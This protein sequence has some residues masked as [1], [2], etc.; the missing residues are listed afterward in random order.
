MPVRK[1]NIT[2]FFIPLFVLFFCLT[3]WYA[4]QSM[5]F[6][7]VPA[8]NAV[9]DLSGLSF[10]ARN[11]KITGPVAYIPNALLTPEEF[12]T[13]E[14]EAVVGAPDD[15]VQYYSS[16]IRVLLP[17][18]GYYTFS[19]RSVDF[20]HRMYV[21]GRLVFEMGRP[22]TSK[23]TSVPDTGRVTL[24]LKAENGELDI[25]QQSSN[26]VHREGGGHSGWNIGPVGNMRDKLAS[27]FRENIVLGCFF[28]LFFVHTILFLLLRSYRANLYFALFCLTWFLRSGIIGPKVFTVLF[29]WI[30]WAV[31]FRI[32]YLSIPVTAAL[33]IALLNTLFPGVLQK[34]FRYALY[35]ISGVSS[36]LFLFSDTV[37]MS[38]ALPVCEA[39]Y[40]PAVLYIVVRFI[41]KQRNISAE[42]G[43]FLAGVALFVFAAVHDMLYYNGIYIIYVADLTAVS[44]LM[45]SFCEAAAIF[46]ATVREVEYAK[47][48]EQR[49]ALENAALGRVNRLRTNMMATISHEMRTPLTVMSVY[50]QL[51]VETLRGQNVDEQ[52]AADLAMISEEAKRLADMASGVMT[53]TKEQENSETRGPIDLVAV[54]RQTARLCSP[55]LAKNKN[56]LTLDLPE[57]LPQI[58]GNAGE[59]AQVLWNLLGN[60]ARHTQNGTVSIRAALDEDN[61]AVTVSDTGEGITAEL[62]PHIFERSVSGDGER[63]GLGLAICK[64]IVDAHGGEIAIQSAK[65]QGTSV[66]FTL[67]VSKE[68][69]DGK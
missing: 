8:E 24:T 13:R 41:Q 45:F 51:A 58:H 22:G 28:A 17:D 23:E 66:T 18:D 49:L 9:W 53:L 54:I 21:N 64:E 34:W 35:A 62:L 55:M 63:T 50:A 11:Y 2:Y 14:A 61:I 47:A 65:G 16:R 20:A 57:R 4:V 31:K 12:E 3:L 25:V 40:I 56:T 39:F 32:E 38:Y 44:M 30:P 26:F 27:D 68:G 48:Q 42:Q 6:V 5:S 59:C 1:T 52:T 15:A 43:V 69:D 37:F 60:A 19:G 29:P 67:S 7:S 33:M 36:I 46:I 10:D